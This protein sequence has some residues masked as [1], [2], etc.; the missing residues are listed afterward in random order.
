MA[1]RLLLQYNIYR[2]MKRGLQGY[3]ADPMMAL[4]QLA[5]RKRVYV[6][7]CPRDVLAGR[8]LHKRPP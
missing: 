3:D 5:D 8:L 4:T 6:L 2:P 7:V 1:E